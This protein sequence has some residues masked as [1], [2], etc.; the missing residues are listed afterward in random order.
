[1]VKTIINRYRLYRA[2]RRMQRVEAEYQEWVW[3]ETLRKRKEAR[4]N[5]NEWYYQHLHDQLDHYVYELIVGKRNTLSYVDRQE[6]ERWNP[7]SPELF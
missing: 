5:L 1:M 4:Q 3:I 6:R 2:H 7:T